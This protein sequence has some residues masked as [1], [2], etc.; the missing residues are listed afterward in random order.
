MNDCVSQVKSLGPVLEEKKAQNFFLYMVCTL[1][2]DHYLYE[3]ITANFRIEWSQYR[4]CMVFQ[5]ASFR[6]LFSIPETLTQENW[7]VGT[8]MENR[9]KSRFCN[10]YQGCISYVCKTNVYFYIVV[11][12]KSVWCKYTFMLG[13]TSVWS[14]LN[15]FRKKLLMLKEIKYQTQIW[16]VH[17]ASQP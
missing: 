1:L 7:K 15:I 14:V 4:T 13:A 10:R 8:T 16:N 12:W 2:I 11:F 3:R 6:K 9:Q 5:S 17:L